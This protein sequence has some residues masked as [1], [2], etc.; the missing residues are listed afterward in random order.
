MDKQITGFDLLLFVSKGLMTIIPNQDDGTV[1]F[2]TA[3]ELS[4]VLSEEV[5]FPVSTDLLNQMLSHFAEF[6]ATATYKLTPEED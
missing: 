1:T 4:E 2:H 5:G 3:D 6:S